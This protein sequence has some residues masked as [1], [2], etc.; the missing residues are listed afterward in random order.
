MGDGEKNW[1]DIGRA[2]ADERFRREG[3]SPRLL[4]CRRRGEGGGGAEE[5]GGNGRARVGRCA[6]PVVRDYWERL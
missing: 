1:A 4:R 2:N 6:L 3:T 5:D